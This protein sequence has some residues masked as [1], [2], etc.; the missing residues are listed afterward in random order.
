M[1]KFSV[2][3]TAIVLLLPEPALLTLKLRTLVVVV[4]VG[5]VIEAGV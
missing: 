4:P 2:P 5:T 1:P 3:V